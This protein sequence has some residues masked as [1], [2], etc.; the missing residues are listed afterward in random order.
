MNWVLQYRNPG[1][2]GWHASVVNAVDFQDLIRVIEQYGRLRRPG[3][4]PYNARYRALNRMTNELLTYV[5]G[6]GLTCGPYASE[7]DRDEESIDES[8]S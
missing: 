2:E 3:N 5:Q 8:R 6:V 1:Y 7:Q 4:A